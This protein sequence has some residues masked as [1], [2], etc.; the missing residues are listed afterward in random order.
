MRF[1]L[2]L[3]FFI[4]CLSSAAQ[5]EIIFTTRSTA[6]QTIASPLFGGAVNISASGPQI[7][8]FDLGA[9]TASVTSAFQGTDL[10]DPFTPGGFLSYDLFNTATT[11]T[12]AQNLDGTFNIDFSLLFELV[13][14]SGPLAGLTFETLDP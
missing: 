2:M 9:G 3:G 12:I 6:K 13:V 1:L 5:G 4:L 8:T 14:T 7:F 11:G 10:P